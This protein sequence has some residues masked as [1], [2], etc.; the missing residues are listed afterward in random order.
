[1]RYALDKNKWMDTSEPFESGSVLCH[2]VL[3]EGIFNCRR[4]RLYASSALA[5]T[6]FTYRRPVVVTEYVGMF[7]FLLSMT[8]IPC[9]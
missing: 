4:D 8:V 5:S 7:W 6:H 3:R 9:Y 2:P 1:M